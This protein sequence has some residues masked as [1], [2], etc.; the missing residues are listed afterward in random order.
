MGGTRDGNRKV[1]DKLLAKNPNYYSELSKKAKKPRGGVHSPG[2]FT[3]GSERAR[4]AGKK[5][6]RRKAKEIERD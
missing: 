3:A 5:S 1:R 6:K 2:S 4:L